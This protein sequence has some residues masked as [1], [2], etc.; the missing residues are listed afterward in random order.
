MNEAGWVEKN[1]PC[2]G[3]LAIGGIGILISAVILSYVVY[4]PLQNLKDEELPEVE[5]VYDTKYLTELKDME[6]RVLTEADLEALKSNII[7][8][9]SPVGLIKMYYDHTYRGFIW[10][11]DRNP[12]PYRFL[13]TIVR[14]YIIEYDCCN[15]YVD[16]HD[17]VEKSHRLA[18]KASKKFSE[19]SKSI[20]VEAD[21]KRK[22][23][24]KLLSIKTNILKFRYGG[25]LVEYKPDKEVTTYNIVDIDYSDYKHLKEKSN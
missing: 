15:L 1:A 7:E 11:C 3:L 18:V 16:L 13:E 8:D 9:E 23:L 5:E 14:K 21:N 10:F 22:Q 6:P 17:E 24:L 25:K 2:T 20:F 12:V 19:P 4:K